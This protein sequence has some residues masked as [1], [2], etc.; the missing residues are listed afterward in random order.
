MSSIP[1]RSCD[2]SLSSLQLTLHSYRRPLDLVFAYLHVLA[3]PQ[4][5]KT[6][7]K[8]NVGPRPCLT[9][10]LQEADAAVTTT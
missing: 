5:P 8:L 6:P 2:L 3:R 4:S 1:I 9:K 7:R 10:P